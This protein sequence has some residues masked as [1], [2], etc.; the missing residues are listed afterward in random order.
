MTYIVSSGTLNPTIPYHGLLNNHVVINCVTIHWS[1]H[2]WFDQIVCTHK[3]FH[4]HGMRKNTSNSCTRNTKRLQFQF[5]KTR[6]RASASQ[7]PARVL[8]VK[9]FGWF[10]TM[11]FDPRSLLLLVLH[12]NFL[13][14]PCGRLS[15]LPV[16][17]L[18]HVKYTLSYRIVSLQVGTM[19][20]QWFVK[21]LR[22]GQGWVR[23]QHV[24]GQGQTT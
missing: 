10:L 21:L 11:Y 2:V 15:W 23:G 9:V 18:L 16:S 14:V 5:I 24:R 17:F 13:F 4:I 3:T 6:H 22:Y 8:R 19:L 7:L 20:V 12:F 1:P